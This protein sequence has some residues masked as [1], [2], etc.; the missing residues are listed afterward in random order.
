M[1][2]AILR[3]APSLV[4]LMVALRVR[5]IERA[6]I[7]A[8]ATRAERASSLADLKVR[9]GGIAYKLLVRRGVLARSG[10]G[11][12]LDLAARERWRR[13]RRTIL[14]IVLVVIAAF[15]VWLLWIRPAA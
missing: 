6:F 8:G 7:E 4:L 9:R 1:L 3:F 13:R 15:L 5:R 10:D 2:H 14:P 12:Y 11:Y